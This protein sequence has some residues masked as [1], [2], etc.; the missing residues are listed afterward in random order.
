LNG[1][2]DNE[3]HTKEASGMS[4]SQTWA[5]LSNAKL[6]KKMSGDHLLFYSL[7]AQGG[8]MEFTD[9]NGDTHKY[10]LKSIH[11]H[12][13]SEHRFE[14]KQRD[15]EVHFV[16]AK[17]GEDGVAADEN[18]HGVVALTYNIAQVNMNGYDENYGVPA[19]DPFLSLVLDEK[20]DPTTYSYYSTST[21][22]SHTWGDW[23]SSI[24]EGNFYAYEGSHTLPSC[25]EIVQFI[26]V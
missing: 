18:G 4:W 12:T 17:Y 26:V 1:R 20:T 6:T 19:H 7:P 9:H 3:R 8:D 21:K 5:D 2:G 16:H 13:P 23:P 25:K 11:I 14:A 22:L 15:L 24:S 10:L